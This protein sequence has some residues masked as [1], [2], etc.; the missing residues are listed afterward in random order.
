[1][2]W[3]WEVEGW[4]RRTLIDGY[5]YET[6]Y[7]GESLLAAVRMMRQAKRN[8]IGCIRLTWRPS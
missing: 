2:G 4:A 5:Q 6:I 8:G 1:M 3:T 7:T